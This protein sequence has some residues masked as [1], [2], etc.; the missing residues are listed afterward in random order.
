[1]RFDRAASFPDRATILVAL[2]IFALFSAII[3]LISCSSSTSMSTTQG[4]GMASVSVTIS[5]P[6]SCKVPAGSFEHVYISINSVQAHTSATAGDNSAG[7][8]ELAPQ[9]ASAPVQVDLLGTATQGCF[10]ATLGSSNALP[11]GSYQQIRLLLVPNNPG[12]SPTPAT[13]NC[14]N[15]GF[16]CAVLNDGSIHELDLSSQANTGL[17]IPPGQIVGGPITVT[18]GQ[19]ITLNID[20]NVCASLIVEGNG[21]Y[22]L[23]PTLTAG[24]V[25]T[26]ANTAVSGQV[27]DSVTGMPIL[28]GT[29]VVALEQPDMNGV[30]RIFMQTSADASGNF[31]FCPLPMGATFDV[32]IV[33]INGAGV[34]YNAAV[35]TN[36]PGGSS[37]GKIPLIA[38]TG[39]A[40]GPGTIQ[41][42]DTALNGAM[43]GVI[44]VSMSALQTVSLS[45]GGMRQVTIPLEG[46][47]TLLVSVQNATTCPMGSPM[48]ANCAQYT[49]IVPAS[50]P[51]VGT[52]SAGTV[53]F[54]APASGTVLFSV[55]AQAAMPMSGGVPD[56]MPSFVTQSMNSTGMPL[57][58][59]AGATT[60]AMLINFSGCM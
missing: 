27:M 29:T 15:Q 42:F 38:E 5:D 16:N 54:T 3:F 44:D 4:A 34:A 23:K 6:P 58:V 46:N 36:V 43:G 60:T 18:A 20:F 59:T 8:Q 52:F 24:Q 31:S 39:P 41:G 14:G 35:V 9:L 51:E 57:A 47:S 22:R 30:D 17:K 53:M 25:S 28:G 55:N 50:N 1:M 13:N 32:V 12:G 10:L 33:A 45:G 48:G 19:N 11:V 2:G 56:C 7:W 21:M 40:T 37:L 26:T 49:L